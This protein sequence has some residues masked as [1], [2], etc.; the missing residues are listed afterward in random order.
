MW[1]QV[2]DLKKFGSCDG[3]VKFKSGSN[4]LSIF[5]FKIFNGTKVLNDP[6]G[7]VLDFTFSK[8]VWSLII[9]VCLEML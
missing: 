5:F 4:E 2:L 3:N 7:L 1:S 9:I 6:N 8:V